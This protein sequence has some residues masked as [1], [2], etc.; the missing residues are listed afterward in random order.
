MSAIG[1]IK[2]IILVIAVMLCTVL[3]A[4][5]FGL[6][7]EVVARAEENEYLINLTSSTIE[8]NGKDISAP[9]SV[10]RYGEVFDD[11]TLTIYKDGD[12]V[13]QIKEVGTYIINVSINNT[14]PSVV[15]ELT[16]KVTP[17][18]LKIVVGGSSEF[19]YS[20]MG[21][22]RN[23]SPLGIC[24][25]D[26]CEIITTY[27][28]DLYDLEP[29]VLPV[30]ADSYDMLFSTDNPNYV[31]GDVEG[32]TTLVI[33]KRTLYVKVNDTQVTLGATPEFTY[34]VIGYV[35]KEDISVIER[36]PVVH[37]TAT[38]VGVHKVKASGGQAKNYLFE[39]QEGHLTINDVKAS[40][41]VEGTSTTFDV[42]GVFAPYTSYT[43]TTI[44]AKS[45]EGKALVKTARDYRMLNF[46]SDVQ[47]IYQL[48]YVT[49]VQVSEKI[50]VV[51][52][53]V[54]LNTDDNYVIVVI[55]PNGVV[56]QIT[57]YEYLNGTLSFKTPSLGTVMIFKDTYNVSVLYITI[58]CIAGF[59]IL[60]FIGAKMQ[61][62][63][64][65]RQ[66]DEA[67]KRREIREKGKYRW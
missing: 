54:T 16:F 53:N 48:S 35:G 55:D 63:N 45:E 20:G 40:G 50:D 34:D 41:S 12:I 33:T 25:G 38:S 36:L 9:I 37:T 10:T 1:K 27:S 30:D 31:I 6:S 47:L 43:G 44:D 18:A 22:T 14:T 26:E 64:D 57:K 24:D 4:V 13:P 17:K 21:Y 15:K 23:V 59:V 46:T 67:K 65:K 39:Y 5:F 52:H 7:T 28:G 56:T 51:F 29:G 3:F 61:Y 32:D 8:Y 60:L 11:Y 2:N 42:S 66:A 58:A 49:G 19:L 62:R